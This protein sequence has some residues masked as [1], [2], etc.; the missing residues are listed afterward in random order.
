MTKTQSNKYNKRQQRNKAQHE[1]RQAQRINR[2]QEDQLWEFAVDQ[3]HIIWDWTT[4]ISNSVSMGLGKFGVV[5]QLPYHVSRLC[6]GG[7]TY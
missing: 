7:A 2:K 1:S 3:L 4:C 5:S 6:T